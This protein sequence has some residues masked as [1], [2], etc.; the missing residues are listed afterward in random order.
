MTT[1][2]D[3]KT[4]VPKIEKI[5]K[6]ATGSFNNSSS[7]NA[8]G[9]KTSKSSTKK[10]KKLSSEQDRY[11]EINEK[12]SDKANALKALQTEENRLYGNSK[13]AKM[14]AETE[15][16]QAQLDLISAKTKETKD[17]LAL[18]TNTL[19]SFGLNIQYDSEGRIANYNDVIAQAVAEYN[20]VIASGNDEAI[21][22]AEERYTTIKD[23]LKQYEETLNQAEELSQ[24]YQDKL[25]EIYDANYK[26]LQ[27][28]VKLHE[29]LTKNEQT[30]I[31]YYSDKAADNIYALAEAF[32]LLG[33]SVNNS[34]SALSNY[35]SDYESTL[36]MFA[37]GKITESQFVEQ[38]QSL[39]DSVYST[40]SDLLSKD[41]EMLEYY[42]NAIKILN[43]EISVHTDH[44]DS[45]NKALEHYDKLL[46]LSGQSKNYDMRDKILSQQAEIAKNEY[47]IA[48]STYDSLMQEQNFI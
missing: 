35:K 6:K 31:D 24:E 20:N 40:L 18:D 41:K 38:T 3:G 23:A 11:H 26:I 7:I 28:Q 27:E 29:Q 9:S 39:Y 5:T 4:K 30:R 46:V 47:A 37:S 10:P 43:D 36:S 33:Q 25:D 1:S 2:T 19:N 42:G 21:E 16:L 14:R 22:A 44:L 12:I 34:D 8:G 48:K 32:N 13:L 17:Y 15:I 45:L